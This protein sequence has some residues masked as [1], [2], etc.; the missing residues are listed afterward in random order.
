MNETA[1]IKPEEITPVKSIG[2]KMPLVDGPEKVSS[3]V[4]SAI[5]STGRSSGSRR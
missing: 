1:P 2:V 4:S 3:V 5:S